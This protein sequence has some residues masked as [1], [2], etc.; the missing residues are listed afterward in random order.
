MS[1]ETGLNLWE[2]GTEQRELMALFLDG[3]PAD[4]EQWAAAQARLEQV[5]PEIERRC[6]G[7]VAMAREMDVLA[8]AIEME[9][10]RLVN[11]RAALG[12]R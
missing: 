3:D 5:Q 8:E 10:I 12:K 7:V 4:E 9:E 1:T 2:L 6:S 11:R